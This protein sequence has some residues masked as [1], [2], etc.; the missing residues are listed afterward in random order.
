MS[1]LN[2]YTFLP[3]LRQG[4]ANQIKGGAGNRATIDVDLTIKGDNVDG[5]DQQTRTISK[6]IQIYGPGDVTGLDNRAIIKVEP[7]NGITNFEPNYFPYIDFYDEDL[8]WRYSPLANPANHRLKPWMALIV[9][10]EDEFTDGKNIKDKP[11][12]FITLAMDAKLPDVEQLERW[13]H[14]HV[15]QDLIVDDMT[16]T[17]SENI[18]KKLQGVLDENPDM[19][20]S[21]IIC[22]RKLDDKQAYHA[23]LVPTF[24]SGRKAGM[25]EDPSGT[26]LSDPAWSA[27]AIATQSHQLP[28]FHRW[29]FST[30]TV[31]DFEYLVRLLE[32]K[33]VDSR[34]GKRDL[35][36]Q[37]PGANIKGII[38]AQDALDTQK[39]DG[40]LKLG[41]ALR[42][43]EASY[44]PEELEVVEKY[45]NWMT[46]NKTE[47]YPHS[48]QKSL[49]GFINLTD[50]YTVESA[51]LANNN[52]DIQ[53]QVS[54]NDSE[55]EYAIQ[56]NPDPL[57][58][59]PLYGRWHALTQ[60][61]LKERD[62][63]TAVSPN[64]N[65]IHELNLD[66]RWRVSAGFGTKIVQ[67]NQEDYM[68]A[69]WDQ[70]GDV[71]EAN[72]KIR[73]AQLA[74]AASEVWFKSYLKPVKEK[75]P[76]KWLALSSPVHKRVLSEG[77]TV[78]YKKKES[79]LSTAIT[80]I[81][82]RKILR[83]GGKFVKRLPFT[84]SINLD[85]LVTRVNEGD[86]SAAPPK[87]IPDGIQKPKD[88]ADTV[89]A[90]DIPTVIADLLE[91]YPWIK[92]TPLVLILLIILFLLLLPFSV[93]FASLGA[94][95]I[96][97]LIYAYKLLSKWSEKINR[98]NSIL[99]ENQTPESV[100]ELL[101]SPDFK[102]TEPGEDFTPTLT[103]NTEGNDSEEAKR[104]KNAL[105]DVN[106]LIQDS[107]RLGE[108]KTRPKLDIVEVNENVLNAV[109]PGI[110]IP[111]WVFGEIFLPPFVQRQFKE[112]F[113]EAMAYPKFDFPM[114]KPLVDQSSELFL[115][116]INYVAQN[117]ISILETNQKFIEAYMVGLNHEFAR[118]LLWREYPTEQ[119][120]SYFRQFWDVSGFMDT[121]PL[122]LEPL[123][124]RF[125]K[126]L[127]ER[128]VIELQ[129]FYDQ[130]NDPEG[131]HDE[132]FLKEAH[133]HLLKEELKD[134]K[135]I[136]YWSKF[137]KI[138][139]HDNRELPGDS[140]EEV[141][142]V[143]RGELLKKYPTAV[144]YAHKAEWT[145]KRENDE[146]DGDFVLDE[147]G[148]KIIDL[149]K[150]RVFA[151]IPA[152]QEEK[153]PAT[154][155]KLPLYEAKVEPDIYFFGFDITVCEAKGGTG[156]ESDAV[157]E[158][159]AEK[160]NWD[161]AGWF[162]VI[163]ERPGEPRF[164]LDVSDIEN[165]NNS[166][167]IELWNDL[168]WKDVDSQVH[169]EHIQINNQTPTIRAEQSLEID[170]NEKIGQQQE[171]KNIIWYENMNSAELAYILYQV[172]V[173][174][175][176]HASEMLKDV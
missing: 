80:S 34:V 86:V 110:T 120:G 14:V 173:L 152:T 146:I 18:A 22:P 10:K 85:N 95:T 92:W 3:W 30:G 66:P 100:D 46:L 2:T 142:L 116:N 45:Q 79:R 64:N 122:S 94:I 109:D 15:N 114:Y 144:I 55:I 111:R 68:K 143:I 56:D 174:V 129:T 58:T 37:T 76:A 44:S 13:A 62:N 6:N 159:C 138:G 81:N 106:G 53:Q 131:V 16:S 21:R 67:E 139:D 96:G 20:F 32:P 36:V 105:I 165:I 52:P 176:V 31:G 150:E 65:W 38:D 118:E 98:A 170:D 127:D 91:R 115:P 133:Q 77:V 145:Y 74:K 83:P 1:N 73:E 43:P 101:E 4:V 121:Q 153:P 147:Y 5:N 141:V 54:A 72:K 99:E 137:S 155:I 126:I 113:V 132:A 12:P 104:F 40:I 26:G 25:G 168:S 169:D 156:K 50:S 75:K 59:A 29:H 172:P 154:L 33:P 157:N 107:A 171:D 160:V 28:Y 70:I 24:E 123:K 124:Q 42:V 117:S 27:A 84:E 149:T 93:V 158:Q 51:E 128:T 23:F 11:L 166:N 167:E 134:I 163:K 41:G 151:E 161:D 35:D 102:I 108:V 39:L 135:P 88:I 103:V 175:G 112:K 19:A 63:V 82:M 162:F 57:I 9:L 164:G 47:V 78:F 71:L 87:E 8:P 148:K 136:N 90:S 69:A 49:A 130:L 7:G 61:L 60:R 97:G 17:A 140:E 125:K 119:R 48:F 89:K